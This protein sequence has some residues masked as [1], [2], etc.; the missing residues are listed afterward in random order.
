MQ[1]DFC[2]TTLSFRVIKTSPGLGGLR[3]F[4]KKRLLGGWPTDYGAIN[5]ALERG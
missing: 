2:H 4:I 1:L 5:I 3:N